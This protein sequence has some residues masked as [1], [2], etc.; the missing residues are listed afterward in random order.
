MAD[1]DFVPVPSKGLLHPAYTSLRG[2]AIGDPLIA[3]GSPGGSTLIN[4]VLNVTLNL[5][6]HKMT[7]QEAID[8]PRQSPAARPGG[9]DRCTRRRCCATIHSGCDTTS[10][11][12]MRSSCAMPTRGALHP[13][14]SATSPSANAN[15]I[16]DRSR[17]PDLDERCIIDISYSRATAKRHTDSMSKSRRSA[18]RGR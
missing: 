9:S 7:L 5:I 3:Y 16:R 13:A 1:A 11:P 15:Q 6:D 10:Q 2:A 8:A 14:S 12:A 17:L 18:K 4:S